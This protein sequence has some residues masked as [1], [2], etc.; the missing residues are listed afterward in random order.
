MRL[1]Y[2][3]L[4]ALMALLH[5]GVISSSRADN[6][7]LKDGTQVEGVVLKIEKGQVSVRIGQ[8]TKVFDILQVSA[9]DFDTPR[10]AAGT[11]RLP[12]EHFLANMEAQ[13]MVGHIQSVEQ[14]A[15]E[16]RGL[17]DQARQQWSNRKTLEAGEVP[18]WQATKER[19]AAPLAQYQENLNDLYFHVLGKVDEY[20]RLIKEADSL[21]VGVKGV[22]QAGSSLVPKEMEK[23]PLKKY[24]P[25]N[26]YDIIFF[27]E[28]TGKYMYVVK[29][30]RVK[31]SRLLPNG[32]EMI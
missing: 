12:L 16:V 21:Y 1:R 14:S 22:F 2:F 32:K 7:E 29:E 5:V 28:D 15:A 24:I 23:L 4:F 17:I 30:G 11:S 6:L 13:E 27:E 20:N 18:Q 9:M 31:V 19:L 10:L 8:D 3:F 25:S 26:W